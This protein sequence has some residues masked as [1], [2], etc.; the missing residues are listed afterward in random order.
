M[1]NSSIRWLLIGLS[2]LSLVDT[3]YTT[4]MASQY[5]SVSELILKGKELGLEGE[6]LR[7][8]VTEQQ[9]EQRDAR[10]EARELEKARIES[11]R[12]AREAEKLAREVEMEKFKIEMERFKLEV[13]ERENAAK[14]QLEEKERLAKL[15]SEEKE[16]LAKLAS[17]ENERITKLELEEKE[18]V[19]KEKETLAK[20]EMEE[21]ERIAKMEMEEKEKVAKLEM[22]ERVRLATIE[23]EEK[24]KDR[25]VRLAELEMKEKERLATV[26]ADR[27]N[28]LELEKIRVEIERSQLE[29]IRLEVEAQKEIERAKL[30]TAKLEAAKN[31]KGNVGK[32]P[33]LPYFDENKDK[34]DSYLARF[35]KYATANKW[36]R[37]RWSLNLSALL[38]GKALEVYDRLSSE[39]SQDYDVLKEA[40]LKNF[41]MTEQGFKKRFKNS[42][43]E[44]SETFTQFA[45]RIGSYLEKWFSL[46]KV[47]KSFEAVLDFLVR[48][49][50]LECSSRELYVHLKPKACKSVKEL[51]KEADLFA[52]AKGGV[53]S[54]VSRVVKPYSN[55]SRDSGDQKSYSSSQGTKPWQNKTN[56]SSA[57]LRNGERRGG[58]GRGSYR[59]AGLSEDSSEKAGSAEYNSSRG[60]MSRGSFNRGRGTRRNYRG[61]NGGAPS[62]SSSSNATSN[63]SNKSDSKATDQNKNENPKE[64]HKAMFCKVKGQPVEDDIIKGI[65]TM[66]KPEIQAG[67]VTVDEGQQTGKCYFLKSRLPTAEGYVEG[68]RVTVLRDTGCTGIVVRQSLIDESKLSSEKVKVTLIDDTVKTHNVAN[69]QIECPFFSGQ[70]QA[71]CMESPLYDLVIGNVDGSKLPDMS[72]F[73]SPVVTRSQKDKEADHDKR[74]KVKVPSQVLDVSKDEF[75]KEQETDEQLNRARNLAKC[76]REVVFK[77]KKKGV[78]RFKH[79]DG[80]LYREY[81]SDTKSHTQLV[82]PQKFRPMVLK[83]AHE[84]IMAG[85][86][87]IRRTTDR[88]LSEFYWQGVC[89]DVSRYCR[90]CDICQKTVPKGKISRIPLGQTPL[91]DTPFKRVAVDIVGPIEPRS[92]DRNRYI[93]TMVD[94]ATR[95]PEA[96]PLKNIEAETVAEALVGMFS[97]VGIPEEM[98]TDCGSQFMSGVMREVSRLLSLQQLTTTPYNPK[99][100]GLVERF[101][102]TLKQML[103][104][105]CNER[106]RDWDKYL[107]A[108]LFAVRE[109]PQESLGFSPFELLYGRTVRGPMSILRDLWSDRVANDEVKLTY[110]YVLDLRDK[111]DQTCK[112]ALENL[113]TE[114]RKQKRYYDRKTKDRKFKVG[115]KVLILLP[116]SRNKLSMQWKGPYEVVEVVNPYDYRVEVKGVCKT[117]HANLLKLYVERKDSVVASVAPE[118]SSSMQIE[119][120]EV[121]QEI[122][123]L[124]WEECI[125][126]KKEQTQSFTDVRISENL[127]P[128]QRGKVTE[129]LKKYKDVLTDLPGK[130]NLEK[131]EI[132]LT[133]CDPIR[134]KGYPVPFHTKEVLEKEVRD[135]LELD[136]IEPSNSPY[137]SPVVLVTKPDK[138]IRV[139]ID[140]RKLNKV[141]VFDAEPMPNMESVFS[142]LA[143]YKYLSKFDLTKGYWQVPLAKA[144]KELT[145]FETPL[146]LFQFKVTPFG[147]VNSGATFCRLMRKVLDKLPNIESFVDDIWVYSNSFEEHLTH[148]ENL[149][150]RLREVGLSAKPSKCNIG[151]EEVDCLGH[152]VGVE[153]LKPNVE[154]VK[155]VEDM[156]RPE[157]KKQ[158]RSFLG[159]VGFYRRFIPNFSAIAVPL[160]DLTKKNSPN[161]IKEWT[162]CHEQA[163]QTLKQRLTNY[164]VLRLPSFNEPF[165]LQTDAS[166]DGIGAVLLQEEDGIKFP[167]AFAS[168]KL[169]PREKNYS[170]IEKECLAIVWSIE[171][172]HRYLFG[173]KF[174]LETDHEP[175]RYLQ[176]A[177]TLNP[178]IM[179]W[180]LKLQPYSFSIVA[181]RGR[182]NIGA[183]CLSRQA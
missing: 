106:Q 70:A 68:K 140:Y 25:V 102:G 119:S 118:I 17:E 166:D 132:K 82:V 183:D 110:Q 94:Y 90:S 148:L 80:L 62:S 32:D 127:L 42:R 160:T 159:M 107:P 108:L 168:K 105:M 154:K 172:F 162:D 113:K 125:C 47:D 138:T 12:L 93:L 182:D 101:N 16:R 21:R 84:S 175:L 11:E 109:V 69:V 145:A 79:K 3:E 103:K 45:S 163:F 9:N 49:Q 34:M 50:I 123:E 5:M 131:H 53:A 150:K 35:E 40:L 126:P 19:A 46:A 147:L 54:V 174:V 85:H 51:A 8:F 181:I 144:S 95:Y 26:E 37:D 14:L 177:K 23:A 151:C 98:L 89:G 157:T 176:T 173:S 158:V 153:G 161:K 134:T 24:E 99:A 139:C 92:D 142:R 77:G 156:A 117:Y 86:M 41:D 180:A 66:V 39:D 130:T 59:V 78:A 121:D 56:N 72:H 38:K 91:I 169:L 120:E 64:E 52:E 65:E 152:R 136:V 146:G 43:P 28:K 22:E 122:D 170:V 57:Q 149:L 178:R 60:N 31:D 114:K 100:N 167:I 164:P 36:P 137:S 87:G 10:A 33:K 124:K 104:R 135:M 27:I 67:N 111:L 29:K 15:A 63:Q 13:V 96:V 116:T 58:I 4:D 97:R 48:D 44:K 71:I 1:V 2:I 76:E 115:E 55:T 30:E 7:V 18:R 75:K 133:S 171:K 74:K 83:V 165:I 129:L 81:V 61:R 112:I 73:A 88:V 143:G 6:Q 20:L 128:N 179:R 155:A 141:T